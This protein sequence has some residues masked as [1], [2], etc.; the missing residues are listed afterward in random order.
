MATKTISIE[1]DVYERLRALKASPSE[2]FSQVL[3]RQLATVGGLP[4]AELSR[5]A[6]Q[7]GGFL[8]LTEKELRRIEES[9]AEHKE[10][11]DTWTR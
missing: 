7:P 2:S 3:R 4:A 9:R 5:R 10:W 11:S 1:I 6:K 8:G